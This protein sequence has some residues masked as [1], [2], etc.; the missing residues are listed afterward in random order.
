MIDKI[1]VLII[2]NGHYSTGSTVLEGIKETDKD[3]GVV[4]PSIFELRRQGFVD[5][6]YLAA[7]NGKKFKNLRTKTEIL[8]KKFGWD[9][10]IE[11]FPKDDDTNENAYL[12]ALEQ[13][14]RPVAVIIVTPDNLHKQ[15]IIDSIDHEYHFLVVK[16]VV[17]KLSDLNEIIL[18]LENKNVLGLV[19]FHKI[20]DDANI[21]I[22][23]NYLRGEYGDFQHIFT[24]M[25]QRRDMLKIFGSWITKADNINHYLGSHYIHLVGFITKATPLNVRATCQYGVAINEYNVDTPDIIE[26]QIEWRAMNG[27]SFISYHV[28]G[29]GDPPETGGMTYQEI[30]IIGT[31][32]HI[33]SDQRNRGFESILEKKGQQIINPYFFSLNKGIDGKVDLE[34]QYGF[35]SIKMFIKTAIDVENGADVGSYEGI[36][37]TIK[38]SLNVTAILEAADESLKKNSSII[39]LNL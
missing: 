3:F 24:K 20:Y 2:G 35:K 38:D 31:K 30:H 26:T 18:K 17:N 34:G 13:I 10:K 4:L 36:L 11:L 1:N 27:S 15:M 14:P 8:G 12:D 19:D 6:I 28:S 32:G 33:E 21:L 23:N 29:W 7:R 16:P 37:P 22:K 5:K 39:K 25:T 9:T